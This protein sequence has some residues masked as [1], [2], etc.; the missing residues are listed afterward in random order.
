MMQKNNYGDV[1]CPIF[2]CKK[3]KVKDRRIMSIPTSTGCL[4]FDPLNYSDREE[5]NSE[6]SKQNQSP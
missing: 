5:A 2:L 1:R 3:S 4:I 6:L